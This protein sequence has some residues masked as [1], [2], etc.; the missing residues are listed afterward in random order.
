MAS[1]GVYD[2]SRL[3]ITELRKVV[4]AYIDEYCHAE[5]VF[6]S[7]TDQ[8]RLMLEILTGMRR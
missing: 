7:G 1:L 2:L 8:G 5:K 4:A 3:D 6:L